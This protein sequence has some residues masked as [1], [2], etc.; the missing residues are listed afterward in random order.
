MCLPSVSLPRASRSPH[1]LICQ[2]APFVLP[3]R[4]IFSCAGESLS[5]CCVCL[6]WCTSGG[7][8]LSSC[9]HVICLRLAV[10]LG[11]PNPPYASF[12][13]RVSL[14]ALA[15]SVCVCCFPSDPEADNANTHA[16]P[17]SRLYTSTASNSQ[18]V[19]F[20][21]SL[22]IPDPQPYPKLTQQQVAM[23]TALRCR[24]TVSSQWASSSVHN[25]LSLASI[26][27]SLAGPN[28]RVSRG[29]SNAGGSKV[30]LSFGRSAD[31]L[32]LCR[33]LIWPLFQLANLSL[34]WEDGGQLRRT[35]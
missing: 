24:P 2:T 35:C 6:W 7:V 3:L 26:A 15:V 20:Q 19:E 31:G 30:S 11:L 4:S 14:S 34:L 12:F 22:T 23:G 5:A 10:E 1:A 16:F 25:T 29:P 21:L 13:V 32:A 33:R 28:P 17:F 8:S 9:L 18:R 27:S